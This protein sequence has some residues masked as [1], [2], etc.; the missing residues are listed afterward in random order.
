MLSDLAI[1]LELLN[2]PGDPMHSMAFE[3]VANEMQKVNSTTPS[4][5]MGL[6]YLFPE[7]CS[8]YWTRFSEPKLKAGQTSSDETRLIVL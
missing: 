4:S 5:A 2:G 6:A 7:L 1:A 8:T 3:P